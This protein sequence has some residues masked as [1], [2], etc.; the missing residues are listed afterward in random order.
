MRFIFCCFM[1][2][3]MYNLYYSFIS[4]IQNRNILSYMILQKLTA[5]QSNPFKYLISQIISKCNFQLHAYFTHEQ[6]NYFYMNTF[7]LKVSVNVNF[8]KDFL[9]IN[10]MI[11]QKSTADQTY[12]FKYLISYLSV[13]ILGAKELIYSTIIFIISLVFHTFHH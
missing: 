6:K 5:N 8:Q 1:L 7:Q 13:S 12:L 9:K 10:D 2:M 11:S 4:Q 3:W